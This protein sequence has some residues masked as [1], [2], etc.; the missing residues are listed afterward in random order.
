MNSPKV[1]VVI[2][3]YN[4][5]QY[6]RDCLEAI[7]KQTFNDFEVIVVDDHSTTPYAEDLVAEFRDAGKLRIRQWIFQKNQGA[8]AARNKGVAMAHGELIAFTDDDCLP[9]NNW[10]EEGIKHFSYPGVVAVEGLINKEFKDTTPTSCVTYT[11]KKGGYMTANMF[12]RKSAFE[13][14][15]GFD[16]RF[17]SF[18]EDTDLGWR[19]EDEGKIVHEAESIV[20]HRIIDYP[21][22]EFVKKHMKLKETYY[23][24]LL[25]KKHPEKFKKSGEF[26]MGL[27]SH[28]FWPYAFIGTSLLT[29][30]LLKINPKHVLLLLSP[31]TYMWIVVLH[32]RMRSSIGLKQL[33]KYQSKWW[34]LYITWWIAILWDIY[35][36]IKA[37]IVFRRVLL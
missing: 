8:A 2:A 32:T 22:W 27:S 1:S 24:V 19:I 11:F 5:P 7:S 18:R 25:Y 34:G 13:E 21:V 6:L 3:T 26:V 31:I 29:L 36:R 35:Q 12:Y 23:D 4:R 9:D 17:K 33:V 37:M 30:L 10:L 15:G 14:V 16:T 20:V 28:M